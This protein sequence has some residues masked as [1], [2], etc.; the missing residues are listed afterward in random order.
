MNKERSVCEESGGVLGF[1]MQVLELIDAHGS[2][3]T[4]RIQ[5]LTCAP[6]RVIVWTLTLLRL[7]NFIE[8]REVEDGEWHWMLTTDGKL[9]LRK[10]KRKCQQK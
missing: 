9:F 8:L 5:D 10:Y 4:Q 6:G 7:C 3:L 2:L 1:P